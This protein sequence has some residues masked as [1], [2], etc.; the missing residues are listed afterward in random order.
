[1]DIEEPEPESWIHESGSG[2]SILV[3]RLILLNLVQTPA[4][5]NTIIEQI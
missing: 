3:K 4:V 5:I 1:M 2:F